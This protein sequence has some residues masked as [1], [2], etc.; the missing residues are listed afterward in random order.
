M[1]LNCGAGEDS[2]ES[3]G[4]QGDQTNQLNIHWKDWCWSSN[5]SQP[6]AKSPLIRKDLDAGK[7][8]GQEEKLRWL[9]S[10]TN[11][12]DMSLSKFQEIVKQRSLACCNSWGRK[13]SDTTLWL[14]NKKV[15]SD[16]ERRLMY[17][18]VSLHLA[19]PAFLPPFTVTHCYPATQHSAALWRLWS[20]LNDA[21]FLHR[22]LP[23]VSGSQAPEKVHKS[24]SQTM[25]GSNFHLFPCLFG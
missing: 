23:K 13:E 25:P 5:T 19:V 9:D 12:M 7:D 8:W 11:S 1:L 3:L 20:S 10:I 4:Q 2:W 18:A 17:H 14:N 21:V 15:L 6:D 22:H 16:S 24:W